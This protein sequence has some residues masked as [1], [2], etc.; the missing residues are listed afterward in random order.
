MIGLKKKGGRKEKKHILL[1]LLAPGIL[2]VSL[3]LYLSS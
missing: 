1:N 3:S 2:C